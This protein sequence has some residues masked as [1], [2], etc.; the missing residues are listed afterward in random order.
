MMAFSINLNRAINRENPSTVVIS[1][2]NETLG[3]TISNLSSG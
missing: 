3:D 2:K 1:N